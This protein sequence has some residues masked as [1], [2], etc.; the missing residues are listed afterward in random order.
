MK[1]GNDTLVGDES[2][3][4][5]DFEIAATRLP[6]GRSELTATQD[7]T[8]VHKD[9]VNLKRDADRRRF[10][11]TVAKKLEVAEEEIE[12]RLLQAMQ[13]LDDEA[14]DEPGMAS[15]AGS[16]AQ[17][18][19]ELGREAELFHG[20]D[21]QA[22]ASVTVND[23]KE[24]F[25]FRS[26]G[27]KQWLA[28]GFHQA[29]GRPPGLDA[30]AQA[31]LTL[32]AHALLDGPTQDVYLRVAAVVEGDDTD[33]PTI[34]IDLCDPERRAV[35][36]TREGW[37]VVVDPPIR[38]RRTRG[39]HPLP[40]PEGGGSLAKLRK[41]VNLPGKRRWRRFLPWLLKAYYPS[42]PDPILIISGE[43][44]SAK[45]SLA[46]VARLL[47]DPHEV[48]DRSPP[49]EIRD[50]MIA[51]KNSAVLSFDN[52]SFL[53]D[54]FAEALCR[55]ST[56]EAF[57]TRVLYSD[58]DEV[59]FKVKHPVILNGI[60]DIV[61]QGDVLDRAI[62][63]H[64]PAIPPGKRKTETAF[65]AEFSMR[66][67]KLLGALLD[68]LVGALEILP[69]LPE[70][71]L[72]RMADFAL[73]GEAV[74]RAA[75]EPAGSF[76]KA[77]KSNRQEAAEIVLD[78]SVVAGPIMA[79]VGGKASQWQGEAQ[80][81]MNLLPTLA[82]PDKTGGGRGRHWPQTPRGMAGV[83]RRLA[84]ALRLHGIVVEFHMGTDHARKRLITITRMSDE[85]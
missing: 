29:M 51:A 28:R 73:F 37:S 64:L 77:A 66:R 25:S 15:E 33:D 68:C 84:P 55:L 23:H 65:W 19:V 35:R 49:R 9:V 54:W 67:P 69:G 17:A 85:P 14:G 76:A 48:I 62:L 56:G 20:G 10:R 4:L 21:G 16:D 72:P 47:T 12:G 61:G 27:F 18:L 81:L 45:S 57:S 34:Y 1:N 41:F 60:P 46:R 3:E 26:K 13:Q 24:T 6:R 40:V 59:L 2:P 43:Q 22:Y 71:D 44:G 7:G 70:S 78:S 36:L 5:V 79:L 74:C 58:D 11:K 82:D 80:D 8:I 32:E 63:E 31:L 39:M 53:P 42:G 83:L 38:F 30:I 52:V 75:G 50:L